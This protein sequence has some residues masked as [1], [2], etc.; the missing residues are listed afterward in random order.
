MAAAHRGLE[1]KIYNYTEEQI[2]GVFRDFDKFFDTIDL[3]ILMDKAVE[4]VFPILD[5]VM[6]MLPHIA[7]RVIQW[8]GF[9]SRTIITNT[10]ILAGCKHSV[11]LTRVL[12]L[13]GI[14]NTCIENPLAAPQ[15]YVDDTAM[16][17]AGPDELAYIMMSTAV[18]DFVKLSHKLGLKLSTKGII[19]AKLAG[20]AKIVVDDLAEIGII[21]NAHESTKEVGVDLSFSK[22]PESGETY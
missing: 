5:L 1:A 22:K 2:I 7:P 21:Y 16:L 14:T 15:V 6:T 3:S 10:S 11:A 17:T 13:T 4:H 19:V 9:C 8:D 12:F 20:T 18:K